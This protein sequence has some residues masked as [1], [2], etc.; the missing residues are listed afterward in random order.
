MRRLIYTVLVTGFLAG[1]A[2]NTPLTSTEKGAIIGGV[3]GA[4]IGK[5]TGDKDNERAV[6]GG[7]VGAAIG[8]GIGNY[9]D[10]Q[11]Q[12]LRQSLQ[13]TGIEVVQQK[14]TNSIVLNMPDNITFDT[15]SS[16]VKAS[17]YGVLNNLAQTMVRYNQTRINVAGHTDSVG[18]DS[19]NLRLSQQ[20]AYNVRNYL[21]DQGVPAQRMKAIGY[22][23]TR[24]IADNTTEQ[25]RAKNRRV[26][27]TLQAIPQQ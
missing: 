23:E 10:K 16:D 25:G 15:G 22:G 24:P 19:D 11:A 3:A 14:E 18:S 21:I 4:A 13:G 1:C 5:S 20:R 8:A 9:M 7:L 27:I 17:S 12:E 2:T 26:E 6:I